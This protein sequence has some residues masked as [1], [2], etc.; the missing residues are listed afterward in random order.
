M[1]RWQ[2][3]ERCI[4]EDNVRENEGMVKLV[5]HITLKQPDD[6]SKMAKNSEASSYDLHDVW[7]ERKTAVKLEAYVA[8]FVS[9]LKKVSALGLEC[10]PNPSAA[11]EMKSRSVQF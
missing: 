10:C 2:S 6:S 5:R 3:D 9:W 4:A 8:Y 1:T 11:E 7:N